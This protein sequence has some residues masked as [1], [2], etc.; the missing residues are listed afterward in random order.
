MLVLAVP[1]AE[2]EYGLR[3]P[4]VEA[5]PRLR[6]SVCALLIRERREGNARQPRM[7]ATSRSCACIREEVA[8]RCSRAF[9]TVNSPRRRG[10]HRDSYSAAGAH[11]RSSSQRLCAMNNATTPY[12]TANGNEVSNM[13]HSLVS[14]FGVAVASTSTDSIRVEVYSAVCSEFASSSTVAAVAKHVTHIATETLKRLRQRHAILRFS[15]SQ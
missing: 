8:N 15:P 1:I 3:V 6:H 7:R 14:K 4:L 10:S 5:L 12:P 9:V 13:C 2:C 11:S